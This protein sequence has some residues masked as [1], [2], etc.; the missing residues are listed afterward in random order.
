MA[1]E[2]DLQAL[3]QSVGNDIADLKDDF[4]DSLDL[5]FLQNVISLTD[6][7]NRLGTWRTPISIVI[8]SLEEVSTLLQEA[9]DSIIEFNIPERPA[10]LDDPV[11]R[12]R[13]H[14]FESDQL[15]EMAGYFEDIYTQSVGNSGY[16]YQDMPTDKIAAISKAV[17]TKEYELDSDDLEKKVDILASKWAND[18]YESAPG[19][20][21]FDVAVAITEFDRIRKGKENTPAKL[22]ADAIQRNIQSA[23]ESGISIE[24]L[25]MDFAR[26]FTE[27]KYQK[28]E[29]IIAAYI[30]EIE[31]V[32]MEMRGQVL[33]ISSILKAAEVDSAVNMQEVKLTLDRELNHLQNWVSAVRS[34][35]SADAGLLKQQISTLEQ[36][37]DGYIGLFSSYGSLFG[38]INIQEQAVESEE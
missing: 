10:E 19:A 17:L 1:N 22:L 35:A 34:K 18:G 5:R 25:H 27:F 28:I 31:K 37:T 36:S 21:S 12:D 14:V 29:A 9:V 38:G 7:D 15:D 24:K 23:F 16:S 11:E 32:Q 30:G 6:T 20:L 26:R 13:E 4:L 8:D 33:G 2:Y 3:S